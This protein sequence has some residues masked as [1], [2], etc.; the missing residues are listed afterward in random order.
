MKIPEEYR[1]IELE[2]RHGGNSLAL[3]QML[4]DKEFARAVYV[5]RD[6]IGKQV[7]LVWLKLIKP[8]Q[9]PINGML[10]TQKISSLIQESLDALRADIA[11]G[12]KVIDRTHIKKA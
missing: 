10:Q 1:T 11:A 6:K 2:H 4:P 8:F 5:Y 9:V 12:R 7:F 3:V